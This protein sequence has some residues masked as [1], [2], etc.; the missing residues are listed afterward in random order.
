MTTGYDALVFDND[1]VLTTP[2]R[3]A[4][5]DRAMRAA[6]D[7]V[8]VTAPPDEHVDTLISPDVP[9][10]RTIAETHEVEAERLW[11]AREQAAIEVQFEEIKA[12]QK[13]VYE[14]VRAIDSFEVPRAIVS[15]NQHETIENI[16]EFFG[17]DSF[18]PCYG[19]E[20]TIQ[21]I[22]RKKPTPYY[23]EQALSDLDASNPL[24]VGDSWVDIAAANAC[25]IDVAFIRREHR[26]DY[27]LN[28]EP[29]HELASL[30]ELADVVP[31]E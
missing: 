1:G 4:A 13:T 18:D 27:E 26:A 30:T 6:F 11:E 12:G 17:F 16:V 10:L 29:T 14:D 15:N 31:T 19:R 28:G 22:E 23:L 3:Q 5:L 8:G 7:A 25:E 20:P 21:G 24:Y 2:T 9:S